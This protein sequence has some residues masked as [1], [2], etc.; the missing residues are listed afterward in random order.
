MYLK[1]NSKHKKKQSMKERRKI[2]FEK[3][4]KID[5]IHSGEELHQWNK[6][7]KIVRRFE[8]K[9]NTKNSQIASKSTT[10]FFF[11]F[12]KFLHFSH[13]ITTTYIVHISSIFLQ[14][15]HWVIRLQ[16]YV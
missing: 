2:K 12:K 11:S 4:R 3:F 14:S 13:I 8:K 7:K 1:K 9:K 5:S 15:S 10:N 16:K 6:R